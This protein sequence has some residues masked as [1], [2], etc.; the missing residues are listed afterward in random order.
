MKI[1]KH[2]AV[3]LIVI[4]AI[5]SCAVTKESYMNKFDT[6]VENVKENSSRYNENDWYKTEEKFNKL[7]G[8]EYKKFEPELTMQEK[9]KI[10]KLIG[11]YRAIQLK[12]GI[13]YL[14]ENLEDTFNETND[15]IEDIKKE[16]N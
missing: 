3:A 15:F 8:S 2:L 14:K 10:A 9:L 16:L 7:A 6:F 4:L 13:K 11:Q 12:T 1:F 5:T